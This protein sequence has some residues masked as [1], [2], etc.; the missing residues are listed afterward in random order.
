MHQHFKRLN[1]KASRNVAHVIQ[2][3]KTEH[4]LPIDLGFDQIRK[5]RIKNKIKE[6][7]YNPEYDRLLADQNS[8][9]I[10]NVNTIEFILKNK[11]PTKEQVIF[12]LALIDSDKDYEEAF[13]KNLDSVIWFNILRAK[14]VFLH[15]NSPK[16]VQT[17]N[18]YEIP[19]WHPMFF[20]QRISEKTSDGNERELATALIDILLEISKH[21]TKNSTIWYTLLVVLTNI[22][23]DQIP[24]ELL[25]YAT[26]WFSSEHNQSVIHG[27]IL[28]DKLLPKFLCENATVTDIEKAEAVIRLLFS[29]GKKEM[30]KSYFLSSDDNPYYSKFYL[31]H[32]AN[33]FSKDETAKKI[34]LLCSFD[35]IFYIA[36]NLKKLLIGV[37][38]EIDVTIV[39]SDKF[40][41]KIKI[42]EENLGVYLKDECG[43]FIKIDE[44]GRY[45]D[46][47]NDEIKNKLL[48]CLLL[49]NIQYEETE[50]NTQNLKRLTLLLSNDRASLWGQNSIFKLKKDSNK[51]IDVFSI[52][53]RDVLNERVKQN[54]QEGTLLIRK[55]FCENRYNLPYFKRVGFFVISNNWNALREFFWEQLQN[56][57]QQKFFSQH[58]YQKEIRHLLY[59]NQKL[60][61]LS[62]IQLLNSIIDNGPQVDSDRQVDYWKLSWYS[63]LRDLEPFK[64]KYSNLSSSLKITYKHFDEFGEIKV[65]KGTISP[66]TVDMLL[67]MDILELVDNISTFNPAWHFDQ[68][69]ISGFADAIKKAIE[70]QP[71]HFS[72]GL[73]LFIDVPY[74]YAY[75]ILNAFKSA[76]I[77][78]KPCNWEG[79]I[80]FCQMYVNG[81]NFFSGK[82]TV[83][84]DSWRV[85][86][87]EVMGIIGEL[88]T[89]IITNERLILNFDSLSLIKPI[90][91][92]LTSNLKSPSQDDGSY[93][94]CVAYS[95][96]SVAG[97]V[98]RAFLDYSLKKSRT[99]RKKN[100]W[101]KDC[102]TLFESTLKNKIID[103][104]ILQGLYFEYFYYLDKPWI[105]EHSKSNYLLDENVWKAFLGGLF[106][107]STPSTKELYIILYPHY[108]KAIDAG[109]MSFDSF[110]ENG[111]IRHI[112]SFY[113]W[114]YE[115]LRDDGLLFFFLNSASKPDLVELVNFLWRQDGYLS[116]L[117]ADE[118][119]IFRKKLLDLWTFLSLKVES[120]IDEEE[121]KVLGSLCLLLVFFS[122]LDDICT[123]LVLKSTQITRTY[124]E[125]HFL[126]ENLVRLKQ[127]GNSINTA[128]HMASILNSISFRNYISDKNDSLLDLVVFLF[129][130]DQNI[131]AKDFC[132]NL[133]R[134]GNTF[135]KELY[136]KY[137]E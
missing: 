104:Y 79:V 26:V 2:E 69:T 105:L 65:R 84:N 132:N 6:K 3:L 111:V 12:I 118:V 15:H 30:S 86:H 31:H 63:A 107:S 135:L 137:D 130:N 55:L 52:V 106:Y 48:A 7:P 24:I 51:I 38:H 76:C 33:A 16:P 49:C 71:Q 61:T 18:G 123:Q 50:E 73:H 90:L 53:L 92:K 14:G 102:K 82:L 47:E 72:D 60:F 39:T 125:L 119:I 45:E 20:L 127:K 101:E 1:I 83:K 62:E 131:A 80:K 21:P 67:Q 37:D 129:E 121:E 95:F 8:Q 94:D 40:D 122:E 10:N 134:Q 113:F 36:D 28:C 89:A 133:F 34:A 75:Q 124:I 103:G 58:K 25:A 109:L 41:L 11:N 56:S 115:D 22:P 57:D 46:I 136:N 13:Y 5:T 74:V 99:T 96:N 19:Q 59:E 91:V 126:L 27:N 68:P 32:I 117:K 114:G 66:F 97:R 93:S 17:K 120:P 9:F 44:I 35:L 108:K 29:I 128:K 70:Q 64:E 42:E 88:F 100:K 112:V 81:T 98:L 77:E 54:P 85:T 4:A 43:E 116:K 23:N 110:P 87:E 78:N